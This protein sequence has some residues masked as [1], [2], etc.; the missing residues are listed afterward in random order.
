MPIHPEEEPSAGL[1]RFL[2]ATREV[3]EMTTTNKMKAEAKAT[4]QHQ[5]GKISLDQLRA[6]QK[7]NTTNLPAHGQHH[8]RSSD[9]RGRRK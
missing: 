9:Y 3:I 1:N 2:R 6:V 5:A 4:A 7:Q 8:N